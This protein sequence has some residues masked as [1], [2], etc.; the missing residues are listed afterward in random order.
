LAQGN[1]FGMPMPFDEA[2]DFLRRKRG[3]AKPQMVA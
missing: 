2:M 3:A 1:Y